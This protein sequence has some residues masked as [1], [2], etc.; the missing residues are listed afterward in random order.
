LRFDI[1]SKRLLSADQLHPTSIGYDELAKTFI[2]YVKKVLAK[3][4]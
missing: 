1:V 3:R 2:A 4:F